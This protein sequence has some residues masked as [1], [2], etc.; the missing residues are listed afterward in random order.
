[1]K[2]VHIECGLGNQMTCYANYLLI[3]KNNND[4]MYIEH[5][6]YDIERHGQGINQWNGF[7]LNNVFGLNPPNIADTIDDKDKLYQIMEDEYQKANGV[8]NSQCA[9]NA[10]TRMGFNIRPAYKI[11][12]NNDDSNLKD[13]LIFNIRE[14][15]TEPSGNRF[16]Y[17]LKNSAF[18]YVRKYRRHNTEL[19]GHSDEN[20]LYP[21]SFDIMKNQGSLQTID[22]EIRESFTFPELDDNNKRIADLIEDSESVSIHARRSDFLRFNNDCYRYG[23]QLISTM[24]QTKSSSHHSPNTVLPFISENTSPKPQR[25]PRP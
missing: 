4:E 14:Y 23:G 15:L 9:L 16:E 11:R 19:Y 21:L 1:M 2:V 10:L 12:Q 18:R 5:L 3:K 24:I 20:L 25:L 22:R 13:K 7:E 6:V 17:H 8:N